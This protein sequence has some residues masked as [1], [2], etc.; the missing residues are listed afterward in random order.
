MEVQ[1]S[2]LHLSATWAASVVV[3]LLLCAVAGA[4]T[5]DV[6]DGSIQARLPEG[7]DASVAPGVQSGQ[8]VAWVLLA[9]FPLGTDAAT[10]EG[11]PSVPRHKV[12][13]AIGDFVPM[14]IATDGKR[15]N[16]IVL[17]AA[18]LS[19]RVS[20]NVRFA[21]RALRLSVS[22]GPTP[23]NRTRQAVDRV[24]ASIKHA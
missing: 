10:R 22:F 17:P 8:R 1:S 14:G 11:G 15:V 3:A 24:L 23:T 9:D 13:V 18:N 7:W 16:S 6:S 20:W 4:G 19:R 21:G 12:L 5:R 2:R